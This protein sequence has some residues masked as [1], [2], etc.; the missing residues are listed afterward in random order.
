MSRNAIIA[1]VLV[2]LLA[3]IVL[4]STVGL[5]GRATK[6]KATTMQATP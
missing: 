1:A 2:A 4:M 6:G 5:D 3:L